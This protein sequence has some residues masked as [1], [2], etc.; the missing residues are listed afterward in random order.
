MAADSVAAAEEITVTRKD[1]KLFWN[2][3]YLI[4]YVGS[5]R[6][7]QIVKFCHLPEFPKNLLPEIL[8]GK[9]ASENLR[10]E[11]ADEN[12][13]HSVEKF[14]VKEFVPVIQEE[15]EAAG[16]E[17][18][19]LDSSSLMIGV[20]PWLY[21]IEPGFQA[22]SY[23]HDYAALGVAEQA[24]LVALDVLAEQSKTAGAVDD[25]QCRLLSVLTSIEKHSIYV[26]PPWLLLN[27]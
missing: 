27:T 17:Q 6:Y 12:L 3:E 23:V 8:P 5:F 25:P 16:V 14:F 19:D 15:L 13:L 20:G 4:G 9:S 18:S 26:K 1:S 2:G 22:S 24:G 21:I 7:G 11:S 10:Q